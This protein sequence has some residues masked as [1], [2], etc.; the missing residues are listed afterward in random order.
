MYYG[1]RYINVLNDMCSCQSNG[2]ENLTNIF[3]HCRNIRDSAY[4]LA[5][6]DIGVEN[7]P[8]TEIEAEFRR[9]LSIGSIDGLRVRDEGFILQDIGGKSLTSIQESPQ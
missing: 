8:K 7:V 6:F 4:L 9:Y 1:T 5:K 2:E 3:V